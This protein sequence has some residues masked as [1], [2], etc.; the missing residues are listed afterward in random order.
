MDKTKLR[1]QKAL[2]ELIL[3]KSLE[4]ITIGEICDKAMLSRQTFYHHFQDKYD[5]VNW[6]FDQTFLN[7]FEKIGHTA[8]WQVNIENF[9]GELKKQRKFYTPAYLYLGQNSLESHHYKRVY[10]FYEKFYEKQKGQPLTYAER[11][12]LEIYCRGAVFM[13]AEWGRSGFEESHIVLTELF[14]ISM[15]EDI[16]KHLII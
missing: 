12:S 1:L 6:V 13:V 3:S 8:S 16:Q 14:K 15:T 5:L 4:K 7:T 9:L 11:F 10:D 2:E